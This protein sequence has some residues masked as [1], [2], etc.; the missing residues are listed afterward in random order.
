[1]SENL[2]SLI[3]FNSANV[4]LSVRDSTQKESNSEAILADISSSQNFLAA[5]KKC[6]ISQQEGSR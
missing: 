6:L 1:M 4:V 5:L 2:D 3:R